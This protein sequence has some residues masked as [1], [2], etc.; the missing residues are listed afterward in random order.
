MEK[1]IYT[2]YS[3]HNFYNRFFINA[4][5]LNKNFAPLNP[6]MNFDYFNG[7]LVKRELV[8]QANEALIKQANEIWVYGI[9]SDGVLSEIELAIKL[10]KNIQFFRVGSDYESIKPIEIENIEFEKKVIEK[11]QISKVR[12]EL[13]KYM[14]EIK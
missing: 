14:E 7:D 8:Y 10:K 3:K 12:E 6:F 11:N 5:V 4:H 9:I 1:T 2:A 13:E